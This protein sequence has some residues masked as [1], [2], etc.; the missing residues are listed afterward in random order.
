MPALIV[1]VTGHRDLRP[2]ELPQLRAE[3]RRFFE[4]LRRDFPDLP[5]SLLSPLAEGADQL[6][7]GIA[8][9]MGIRVMAV[10]PVPVAAYRDDFG[11]AGALAEFDRQLAASEALE[12]GAANAGN[13]AAAMRDGPERDQQY[14]LAGMFTSSHC[15]I[16]LALWDGS[17]NGHLGGTA[18]VVEY[19]L[20]GS[21]PGALERRHAGAAALG[22]DEETLVYHIPAGRQGGP[23]DLSGRGGWISSGDDGQSHERMPAAFSDLFAR[24]AEFQRDRIRYRQR[25][26][27]DSGTAGIRCPIH[28]QF[29]DAD[30]LATAYRRRV[31]RIL[32][33]TYVLAALM[34]YAFILY[35]D[36]IAKDLVIYLFLL[37]FLAGIGVNSVA[38]R[39]QWHR[40]YIDYR[41]LAEGLRV[42]SYWRRAGIAETTQPSFAHDNF[43]QKQDVELGWIRN[44]MRSASL[45]GI[46]VPLD[47]V[48][49]GLET[50]IRE[51]IG[52]ES[53]PGQL[54]YYSTTSALRVRQHRRN[55]WLA[56]SCLWTGIGISV[57]LAVFAHALDGMVQN[58]MVAMMGVLSVTAA[59]H[60]AYAYKK[61]DKELI[62]Q[63][64][65]M[66]RIFGAAKLRLEKSDSPV[67]KR[68][69]LRTLGEAA[70]AE[71]AEWTLMHRER[72]LEH[73]KL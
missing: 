48:H 29:V 46:L 40:Q 20:H 54:Q 27:A 31:K 62:K 58:L 17:V 44:V 69:I 1:G 26:A 68:R 21:M 32:L 65:F 7:T 15:H 55:Q 51:W 52:S 41:A 34:G 72:P 16:L 28:R 6:V 71:H 64:R 67:E 19:H 59:V 8:L 38:K 11:S 39:R 73:H 25:I 22:L 23:G 4:G 66:E 24:Q 10:L 45:Q 37:F 53:H 42:Q 33:I 70:L 12:I 56:A 49:D 57:V 63:Y 9:E 14:A 47:P 50:V 43:L 30:W 13:I 36:L 61:A 60:E 18:Q 5:L 3:V 35:S 2:R